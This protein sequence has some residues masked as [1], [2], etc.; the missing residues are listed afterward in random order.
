MKNFTKNNWFKIIIAIVSIIILV[1]YYKNHTISSY[2]LDTACAEE[3]RQYS[4]TKTNDSSNDFWQYWDV[5]ESK[6]V[7]SELTCY[8]EFGITGP[9]KYDYLIYNLTHNKEIYRVYTFS[10]DADSYYKEYRKAR[11]RIFGEE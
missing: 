5:M 10:N 8:A 1:I 11:A 7:K 6:F 4:K 2:R 9:Q 3:A